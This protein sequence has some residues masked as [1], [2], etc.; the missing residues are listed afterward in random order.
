MRSGVLSGGPLATEDIEGAGHE[1]HEIK[2]GDRRGAE[3]RRVALRAAPR[4]SRCRSRGPQRARATRPSD[5]LC[6][7]TTSRSRRRPMPG[8]P[9]LASAFLSAS[10]TPAIGFVLV[11][12]RIYVHI[13]RYRPQAPSS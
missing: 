8:G 13:T 4:F 11:F 12:R 10:A 9:L 6:V 7:V 1:D 2:R 5:A 3:N